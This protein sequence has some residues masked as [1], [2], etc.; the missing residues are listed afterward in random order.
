M[1][2]LQK[3][4]SCTSYLWQTFRRSL[5]VLYIYGRPSEDHFLPMAD[6]QKITS[7]PWQ[8]F[9]RSLPA[10]GRPSEDH[11]LSM[12]DLQKITSCPWQTCKRSLPVHG[13]TNTISSS[14]LFVDLREPDE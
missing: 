13:G 3:I 11:F 4:T 10:H 14:T 8:T 6:L 2:D 1:V 9:R 7:Y 5:P 12:A